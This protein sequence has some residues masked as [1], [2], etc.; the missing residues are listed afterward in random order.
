LP[1]HSEF[2]YIYSFTVLIQ[3]VLFSNVQLQQ[4][5]PSAGEVNSIF[6]H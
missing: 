5:V 1:V 6:E 4:L 2:I 3:I